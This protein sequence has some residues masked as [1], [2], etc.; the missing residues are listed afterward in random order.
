MVSVG[1]A[2]LRMRAVR[3][4]AAWQRRWRRR[5]PAPSG[6]RVCATAHRI[7]EV[8]AH[9][10]R[11]SGR[12]DREPADMHQRR[13]SALVGAQADALREALA[14]EGKE[15]NTVGIFNPTAED[16]APGGARRDP[17]PRRGAKPVAVQQLAHRRLRHVRPRSQTRGCAGREGRHL[18]PIKLPHG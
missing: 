8:D 6:F 17:L 2:G 10:H 11:A 1:R 4:R 18:W 15:A 13:S 5:Q 9:A 12:D 3:M 14:V 16:V 7:S